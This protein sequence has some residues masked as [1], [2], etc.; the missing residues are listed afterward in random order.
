MSSGECRES[1]GYHDEG[2]YGDGDI[3]WPENFPA[4]CYILYRQDIP[5][6]LENSNLILVIKHL[7]STIWILLY[8]NNE[9]ALYLTL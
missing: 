4:Y 9:L 2:L 6:Q 8:K 7:L 5:L 1:V 3:F